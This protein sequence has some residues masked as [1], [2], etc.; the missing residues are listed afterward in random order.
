MNRTVRIDLF[1]AYRVSLQVLDS[2]LISLAILTVDCRLPKYTDARFFIHTTTLEMR[3][4][5][6][7]NGKKILVK[8]RYNLQ[9]FTCRMKPK[10]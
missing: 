5:N 3:Q 7:R 4:N 2:Q 1:A 9:K 6:P 8:R 10:G